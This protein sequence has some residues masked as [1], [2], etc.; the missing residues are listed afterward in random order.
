M[1][2]KNIGEGWAVQRI[3][4]GMWYCNRK[5]QPVP[6][7]HPRKAAFSNAIRRDILDNRW[8]PLRDVV[9][10]IDYET[11]RADERHHVRSSRGRYYRKADYE[12][13]KAE[14]YKV[15]RVEM[16]ATPE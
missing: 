8:Y 12:R 16:I 13:V 5:W 4:D 10:E 3:T 6:M 15:Y 11:G 2:A 14:Q 1:P 9:P 7:V